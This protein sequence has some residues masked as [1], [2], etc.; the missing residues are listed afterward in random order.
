M[1]H[2]RRRTWAGA[3]ASALL[4][5]GC[6][7]SSRA[8][9]DA[10][11][12]ALDAAAVC[13]GGSLSDGVVVCGELPAQGDALVLPADTG[14]LVFGALSRGGERFLTRTG[15]L[16]L[17]PALAADLQA[18]LDQSR[19]S[20]DSG[21]AQDGD[22]VAQTGPYA[23]LVYRAQVRDGEVTALTPAVRVEETALM[24]RVLGGA[25]L[26]GT[27]APFVS[28]EEGY[29]LGA[30]LPVRIEL[31]ADAVDAVLGG[32]VVNAASPVRLSD[33]SCAPALSDAG[34]RDPLQDV[35]TES[36]ELQRFPSMHAPFD[37]ELL[38]KWNDDVS[39][40]GG[41]LFPSAA[42]L[43][44]LEP[45]DA[46]WETSLHGNPLAGPVVLLELVEG[47]GGAC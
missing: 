46:T 29:E 34:A 4:L 10:P 15:A 23:Q 13:P 42:T 28:E 47:G 40:M 38:L 22:V 35:F 19:R 11:P 16:D 30:T 3:V 24:T 8:E 45:L 5:A 12:L 25:S 44:G 41:E 33:G 1:Q 32:R 31:A 27:I 6:G 20:P 26:E 7:G 43:L 2:D 37:D 14:A 39:N 36:V 17:A 18:E 9:Q 21:A